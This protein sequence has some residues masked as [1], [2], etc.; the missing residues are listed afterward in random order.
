MLPSEALLVMLRCYIYLNNRY[1]GQHSVSHHELVFINV[2]FKL[3]KMNLR[4][5]DGEAI[6]IQVLCFEAVTYSLQKMTHCIT[7]SAAATVKNVLLTEHFQILNLFAHLA[8]R[9]S[10]LQITTWWTSS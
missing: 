8:H 2:K 3:F 5:C 6:S 10:W 4:I 7:V 1:S 9:G